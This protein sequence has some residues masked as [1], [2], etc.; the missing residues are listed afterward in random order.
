MKLQT[1]YQIN[2]FVKRTLVVLLALALPALADAAPA[3]L[4]A[5]IGFA[6]ADAF[7]VRL[8][9]KSAEKDE[10]RATRAR[11]R[12]RRTPETPAHTAEKSPQ[13]AA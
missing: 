4:P 3:H 7:C 10:R 13:R 11:R 8:L 6:L 12:M 2:C 1:K 9:W 5:Y